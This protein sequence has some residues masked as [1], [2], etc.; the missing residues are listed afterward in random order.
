MKRY[1]ALL[2][3]FLLIVNCFAEKRLALVIGNSEYYRGDYLENPVN[4]AEDVASKLRMCGFDVLKRTNTSLMEMDDE[5]A[6]F[7][8]KAC[9]YD[10]ILFYYS[11]HGL[12]SKG[13]NF[14]V[15]IDAELR[16]E[17][18]IKYKCF[19]LG[20]L[21]DKL[22]ES[23][24]KMKIVVLDACRNNPF[25]KGRYRGTLEQG[26]A[27]V[28]PPRGTFVTFSTAAG[29][30][31]LDG[32]GRNSPYTEAFLA[33]LEKPNLSLFDFFN[34]V[35]KHVLDATNEEQDPWSNHNTMQG[36]FYFNKGTLRP[37][38]VLAKKQEPGTDLLPSWITSIA[39]DEYVGIS[40]P[41]DNPEEARKNALLSATM[42]YLIRQGG[43]KM[44][45]FNYS[46][47]QS[48]HITKSDELPRG[49]DHE[50][51][52]VGL[53]LLGFAIDVTDEFFNSNNE[54]FVRCRFT[55]TDMTDNR[56]S[57][58]QSILYSSP[59][60]QKLNYSISSL[61]DG[62]QSEVKLVL[63]VSKNAMSFFSIAIDDIT[64]KNE[65]SGI[66]RNSFLTEAKYKGF[67]FTDIAS[68]NNSLG[69]ARFCVMAQL[70][71]VPLHINLI[72]YGKN[73]ENEVF[74]DIME[75]QYIQ[76]S[77]LSA[78]LEITFTD[79]QNNNLGVSIRDPYEY[80]GFEPDKPKKSNSMEDLNMQIVT[81]CIEPSAFVQSGTADYYGNT[82]LAK[83]RSM[84]ST[85][86]SLIEGTIG[87]MICEV[88][89]G[90]KRNG[91]S[92][93]DGSIRDIKPFFFLD[94]EKCTTSFT[95]NGSGCTVVLTK[96]SN[97]R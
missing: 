2:P 26:L 54:Y 66:Y 40:I 8:D 93:M 35:G 52:N 73:Y 38:Y 96:S 46:I 5:I 74:T 77:T 65:N 68:Y 37:N 9:N 16:S 33:T 92:L 43:A 87:V 19:P 61:I 29:S 49:V 72:S 91:I 69:L 60:Y 67:H 11:G 20:L 41:L 39:K 22:D 25:T 71:I 28:N 53:E 97:I 45:L 13:E 44:D 31:A 15:P 3:L 62:K 75:N 47:I 42:H 95:E 90:E 4:D 30:V 50:Y 12:Q 88:P 84:Y 23:N 17:S 1:L 78:P 51:N 86:S 55:H 6:S 36:D 21:L 63:D 80:L 58:K 18:D 85:M 10:V 64:I 48:I 32:T 89:D 70:P 82:L 27:S 57:C 59:E 14:L 81:R 34:N 24:S 79:I 76:A 83:T 94:S 56:I 7:A